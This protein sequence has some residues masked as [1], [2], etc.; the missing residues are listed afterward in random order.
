MKTTLLV[1]LALAALAHAATDPI[2][3][4]LAKIGLTRQTARIDRDAMNIYGGDRYRLQLYDLFM[5][6]PFKMPDYVP[7]FCRSALLNC[8][9]LGS[10]V[11]FAALRVKAGT[12]RGLIE[13]VVTEYE[14]RLDSVHPFDAAINELYDV[15]HAKYPVDASMQEVMSEPQRLPDSLDRQLALLVTACTQSLKWR[16][17]AFKSFSP[18]E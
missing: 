15:T 18:A 12:R 4:A 13:P 3:A 1:L 11:T 8:N 7:T 14:A 2:D 6:D 9:S 17:L 10:S 5:D 16:D